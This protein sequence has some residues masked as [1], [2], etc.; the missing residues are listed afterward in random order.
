MHRGIFSPLFVLDPP[1][2]VGPPHQIITI[3]KCPQTSPTVFWGENRPELETMNLQ[4]PVEV[5][6]D[7]VHACLA[8]DGQQF[9]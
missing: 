4:G 5:T 3:K 1:H 7:P 9:E 6:S 8:F 2:A